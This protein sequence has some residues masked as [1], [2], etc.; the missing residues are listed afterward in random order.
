MTVLITLTIAGSDSGPFDLYSN[1]DGYVSAFESGVSKASLLAGYSSTLVP[2]FTTTIRVKSNGVCVNYI[3]IP[4]I[5]PTTTTTTTLAPLDFE[6]SSSCSG[7]DGTVT[8]NLITGGSGIYEIGNATFSS[9]ALALANSSWISALSLSIGVG[10]ATG[11]SYWMVVRDSIA[12]ILAKEIVVNCPTTTTTTTIS[13]LTQAS[14]SSTSHPTDACSETLDTG[15]WISN[16]G[17]FPGSEVITTGSIVYTDP[18]GTILFVGDG[19]FYHIEI[20]F[21][22]ASTSCQIGASGDVISAIAICP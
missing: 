4:V 3:D 6:I 10:P 22:T 18:G 7:I 2:D 21:S 20:D 14:I 15:C 5:T 1:L 11:G 9:E 12:N 8:V 13:G 16:V 17:G 19:N